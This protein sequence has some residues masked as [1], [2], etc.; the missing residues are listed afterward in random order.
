[1]LANQLSES[2]GSGGN[3][4]R[5][6]T[7]WP[8]RDGLTFVEALFINDHEWCYERRRTTPTDIAGAVPTRRGD[9]SLPLLALGTNTSRQ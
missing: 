7:G 2:T 1:M 8:T 5:E 9:R 3:P 4:D 6:A